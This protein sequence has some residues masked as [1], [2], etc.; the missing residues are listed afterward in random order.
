VPVPVPAP[1]PARVPARVP[2]PVPVPVPVLVLVLVL[3]QVQVQAPVQVRVPVRAQ[4]PEQGP[5][6]VDHHRHN[7]PST[8]SPPMPTMRQAAQSPQI[9]SLQGT[10]S[11]KQCAPHVGSPVVGGRGFA[12]RP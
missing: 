9:N 10:P 11:N 12:S 6:P 4:G 1:V 8:Q 7:L 5:E 2:V 3:V